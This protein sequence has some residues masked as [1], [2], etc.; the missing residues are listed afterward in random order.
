MALRLVGLD[1]ID[2][3]A[4]KAIFL[5][6]FFGLLRPGERVCG[7]VSTHTLKLSDIRVTR[8]ELIVSIQSSKTSVTPESVKLEAKPSL[9]VCPVRAVYEYRELRGAAPGLFFVG[10]GGYPISS[11]KT[12]GG[13]EECGQISWFGRCRNFWPLPAYRRSLPWGSTGTLGTPV[14]RGRQVEVQR[15]A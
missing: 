8:A 7:A 2:Q 10:K 11:K 5:L 1:R 6:G 9:D 12:Y 3:Q 4:F 13:D 15:C 14:V